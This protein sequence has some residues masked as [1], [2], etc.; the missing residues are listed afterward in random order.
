MSLKEQ[1]ARINPNEEGEFEKVFGKKDLYLLTNTR[2]SYAQNEIKCTEQDSVMLD[3]MQFQMEELANEIGDRKIVLEDM[4]VVEKDSFFCCSRGTKT[5]GMNCL[6]RVLR[7][8]N[9]NGLTFR[10]VM[11]ED[12]YF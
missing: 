1:L 6:S 2:A 4:I 11:A 9:W 12:W 3:L 5:R 7:Q 10:N 8:T